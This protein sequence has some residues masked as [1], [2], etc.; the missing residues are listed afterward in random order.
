[1]FNFLRKSC[2]VKVQW[3]PKVR[4]ISTTETAHYPHCTVAVTT[5]R[6]IAFLLFCILEHW[7]LDLQVQELIHL[8]PLP[9]LHF[10]N[11]KKAI[12][13][14]PKVIKHATCALWNF[15]L[16]IYFESFINKSMH[17]EVPNLS[18]TPI[19][20][21][22]RTKPY[23]KRHARGKVFLYSTIIEK[24]WKLRNYIQ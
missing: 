7:K 4:T 22:V 21:F 14:R 10:A 17:S 1:M 8:D 15:S 3:L 11:C 13:I 16:W 9:I 20:Q 18:Q 19:Q 23:S 5:V 24:I 2:H 6:N 12:K